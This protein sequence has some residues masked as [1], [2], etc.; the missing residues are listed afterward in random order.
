MMLQADLMMLQADAVIAA[1]ALLISLILDA[2]LAAKNRQE[3]SSG[4]P[5]RLDLFAVEQTQN[6]VR[7]LQ[8]LL[9]ILGW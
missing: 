2:R 1:A 4:R 8:K 6:S 9:P 7:V 5:T 3:K